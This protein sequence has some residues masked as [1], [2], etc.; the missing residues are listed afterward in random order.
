MPKGPKFYSEAG[1]KG[2]EVFWKKFYGD[3]QFQE[4]M[5]K[6]WKGHRVNRQRISEAAK[7]GYQAFQKRYANDEEFRRRMDEKLVIS[8]SKGGTA[9]LRNLGE[10]GFKKRFE[11]MKNDLLRYKY[12]DN[13]GNRLRSWQELRVASLLSLK[14]VSYT[15]E[16]RFVCGLHSFYPDFLVHSNKQ[17]I[18]EVMGV[19]T[20]E[21]WKKARDK[22]QL[23]T[24][25]YPEIEILV[26][27]SYSKKAKAYL[28]GISR[29]NILLWKELKKVVDW[30]WDT[31]PG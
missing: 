6:S 2:A 29:V 17:K 7:L 8:R 28:G 30:C 13:K 23:L 14:G 25:N 9:S 16:P 10:E 11:E 20:E 31:A 24:D 26:I 4:K 19:G 18:I 5:R 15:V 21:Y 22:V 3:L 12:T 27:T 1:R